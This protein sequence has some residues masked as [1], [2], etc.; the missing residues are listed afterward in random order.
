MVVFTIEVDDSESK[1]FKNLLKKFD[2]VRIKEQKAP[3]L[4]ADDKRILTG[5][6]EAVKEVNLH[7][8]GKV[9]LQ[10]AFEMIAEVEDEL[11]KEG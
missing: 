8:Q 11:K 3:K 6:E 4:S 10:D 1:F 5:I 2:F 9:Q 7:K